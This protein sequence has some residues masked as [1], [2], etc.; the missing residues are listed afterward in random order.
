MRPRSSG[1]PCRHQRVR[2]N[3]LVGIGGAIDG[4][5]W[6]RNNP[7]RC[8]YDKTVGTIAQSDAYTAALASIEV[9][10]GLVVSAV[11]DNTLSARVRGQVTHVY[12]N[13]RTVLVTLRNGTRRSGQWII[14]GI[15]KHVRRLK[16]SHNRVV[17]AWAPVSPIFEL[18]QKA[19]QL[20]QRSTDEER[21][22]TG[23]PRLT[24]SMVQRTQERL[25]RAS[26]QMPATVGASL[27]RIDT[28]WPG[29]HTRRM[30]DDLTKRQR[31]LSHSFV[32]A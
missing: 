13:N 10:L 19:K 30:Y 14:S 11:Y 1:H 22:V 32:L 3:G 6:I 24:R 18:G 29:K 20:A 17:F 7:E 4:I 26:E 23:R 21:V 28:A 31:V 27:R 5:D 16:E 12:T 9:G 15:L 25:G 8:E 2:Q